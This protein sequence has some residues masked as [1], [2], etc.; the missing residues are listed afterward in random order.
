[1]TKSVSAAKAP[2]H[3]PQGLVA[4]AVAGV[5]TIVLAACG[6]TAS[7]GSSHQQTHA[8]THAPTTAPAH[9]VNPIPQGNGG[10]GDADNNGGPSDGDGNI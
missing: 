9:S 10:D 8:P 3:R 6:P 2:K 5:A 4:L 7:A 1:M